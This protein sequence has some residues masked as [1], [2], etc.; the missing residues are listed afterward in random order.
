MVTK[1]SAGLNSAVAFPMPD[2]NHKEMCRFS[3]RFQ[4]GYDLIV[5]RL[6]R[7]RDRLLKQIT[8]AYKESFE[9]V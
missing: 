8:E 6:C 4:P 9:E 3:H 5:E 2:V 7:I 1:D